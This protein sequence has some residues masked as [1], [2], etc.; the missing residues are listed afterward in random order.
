MISQVEELFKYSCRTSQQL[1]SPA[2]S[3][4]LGSEAFGS[5]LDLDKGMGEGRKCLGNP[6]KN[7]AP[8]LFHT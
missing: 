8:D 4:C 6:L 1:Y 3:A 7:Q 2:G 5:S